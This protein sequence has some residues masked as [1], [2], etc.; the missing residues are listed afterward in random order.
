MS[1]DLRHKRMIKTIWKEWKTTIFVILCILVIRSSFFNWYTIPSSSMNPILVEGDLVT[2]NMLAY[3]FHLP[4]TNVDLYNFSEP[5]R[6]DIIATFVEDEKSKRRFVKRVIAKQNDKI[7]M[8]NN[9]IYVNG[10][11]LTQ[12]KNNIDLTRLPN[13]REGFA[14]DSY[15]ENNG[16]IEYSI[17]YANSHLHE[18]DVVKQYLKNNVISNFDEIT[19]PEGKYF[20]MGDNR[21]LSKDSRFLG[22]TDREDVIGKITGVTLNYKSLYTDNEVRLFKSIY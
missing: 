6:G 7:K 12:T 4:F 8:V 16:E 5:E 1:I 13:T 22:F 9:V 14:F 21:N 11:E 2:V 18:K 10:N 17:I 19:V 20:I 3:D 15:T